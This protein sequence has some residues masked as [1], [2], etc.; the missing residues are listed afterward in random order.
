MSSRVK[1]PTSV[2]CFAAW[3]ARTEGRDREPAASY[4]GIADIGNHFR[5]DADRS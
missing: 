3:G 5:L 1:W 2:V 4:E